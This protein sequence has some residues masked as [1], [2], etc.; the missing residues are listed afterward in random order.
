MVDLSPL[1]GGAFGAGGTLTGDVTL[2]A[3]QLAAF[4]DGLTYI[5]LHTGAN[6]GGEIRGQITR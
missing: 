2:T 5:N 6:S 4:V 1:N 3:T